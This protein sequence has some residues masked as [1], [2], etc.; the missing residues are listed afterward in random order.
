MDDPVDEVLDP[1]RELVM[2]ATTLRD[3][4]PEAFAGI[5]E[6]AALRATNPAC[7]RSA[8]RSFTVRLHLLDKAES[9][10]R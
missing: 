9:D 2:V 7:Y 10:P 6:I 5:A 8:Q 3:I 1:V 4:G